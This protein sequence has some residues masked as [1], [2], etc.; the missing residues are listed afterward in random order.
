MEKSLTYGLTHVAIAVENIKT[1]RIFYM[2]VFGMKEMYN[3][4]GFLQLTTP[5]CHDVMVFEERKGVDTGHSGGI[6]HFGFRL[7]E[8]G[9]INVIRKKVYEAG[10]IVVDEGEFVPGSPY[11]FFKDPDGYIIEVWYELMP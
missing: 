1:T 4:A 10:A 9:G 3:E 6:A 8:P 5:G 2:H 11:I 7:R